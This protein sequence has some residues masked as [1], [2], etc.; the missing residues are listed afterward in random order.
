MCGKLMSK[1]HCIMDP[2]EEK[3]G[4]ASLIII[5]D[6][7]SDA[8]FLSFPRGAKQTGYLCSGALDGG[9]H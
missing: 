3:G 2:N 4:P 5:I 8:L 1:P 6:H 7:D 9:T